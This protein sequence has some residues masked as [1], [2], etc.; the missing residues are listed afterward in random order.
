V[1]ISPRLLQQRLQ[2]RPLHVRQIARI[3][4]AKLCNPQ[5][6]AYASSGSLNSF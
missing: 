5:L 4:A 3:H 2:L 6:R 1:T